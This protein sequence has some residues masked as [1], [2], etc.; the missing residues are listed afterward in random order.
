MRIGNKLKKLRN[1]FFLKQVDLARIFNV[2]PQAVSKWEKDENFP[3]INILKNIAN[4]FDITLDE[5]L[6][7]EKEEREIFE[8]TI[9]CSSINYF[10]EKGNILSSKELAIWT[11]S[12]FYQMTE[13]VLKNLGVPI[14][15]TGDGFLCFFSGKNHADKALTSAISINKINSQNNIIIFLHTGEIYFGLVGHP[16]YASKDIYGD[17]VNKNY[18]MMNEFAKKM[19][20]GIG[21]SLEVKEKIKT[22]YELEEI[23]SVGKNQLYKFIK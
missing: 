20:R 5:L 12:I 9:F 22:G 15:Y 19:K 14:K 10:L 3:D 1:D 7:I 17:A 18:L 6:G 21:I 8:A 11:N 13:I 16:E 4:F 2:T 23:E